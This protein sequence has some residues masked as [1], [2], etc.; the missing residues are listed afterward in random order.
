MVRIVPV[1]GAYAIVSEEEYEQLSREYYEK[2]LK[3][4]YLLYTVLAGLVGLIVGV[5]IGRG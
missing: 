2:Q 5:L 1:K 4:R 3:Q